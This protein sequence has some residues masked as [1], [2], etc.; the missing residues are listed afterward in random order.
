MQNNRGILARTHIRRKA[1]EEQPDR[2][3]VSTR[4]GES[5]PGTAAFS[6]A[7]EISTRRSGRSEAEKRRL[8][9]CADT[10]ERLELGH[11][12]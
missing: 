10:S 7:K 2:D 9:G 4:E 5:Q 6:E 12:E 1:E 3:C 8:G 11:R